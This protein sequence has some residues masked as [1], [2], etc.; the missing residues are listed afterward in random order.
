[1]AHPRKRLRDPLIDGFSEA[2]QVLMNSRLVDA[3]SNAVEQTGKFRRI[4]PKARTHSSTWIF[5]ADRFGAA[6][7]SYRE[8]SRRHYKV[9]GFRCDLPAV[10]YR[11]LPDPR[12]LLSPNNTAPAFALSLRTTITDGWDDFLIDFAAIATRFDGVPVM[13]QTRGF[14]EAQAARAYGQRL[15]RFR[16]LRRQMDPQDRLLN[17]FF[18]EHMG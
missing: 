4:G 5:P 6:L 10:A 12:T 11:L 13:N 15:K 3:G 7:Y 16:S 14:T 9:S 2:T 8:F 1:M 17:Q 18:A